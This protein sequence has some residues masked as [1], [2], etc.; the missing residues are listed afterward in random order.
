TAIR[1]YNFMYLHGDPEAERASPLNFEQTDNAYANPFATEFKLEFDDG[2]DN[3]SDDVLCDLIYPNIVTL[4][5]DIKTLKEILQGTEGKQNQATTDLNSY[6]GAIA[7]LIHDLKECVK[8][9]KIKLAATVIKRLDHYGG[10]ITT[11]QL[12]KYNEIVQ[13]WGSFQITKLD[14]SDNLKIKQHFLSV[15]DKEL[16]KNRQASSSPFK[17]KV[18]ADQPNSEYESFLLH[19][20]REVQETGIHPLNNIL[21]HPELRTDFLEAI[22]VRYNLLCKELQESTPFEKGVDIEDEAIKKV[23]L[24]PDCQRKILA[25]LRHYHSALPKQNKQ[26][27]EMAKAVLQLINAMQ[28]NKLKTS[29]CFAIESCPKPKKSLTSSQKLFKAFKRSL[30]IWAVLEQVTAKHNIS[31]ELYL[32]ELIRFAGACGSTYANL[33]LHA[34]MTQQQL[35]AI[36]SL[37]NVPTE[38]EKK[39]REKNL[40]LLVALIKEHKNHAVSEKIVAPVPSYFDIFRQSETKKTYD[41]LCAMV[42][43]S[44]DLSAELTSLLWAADLQYTNYRVSHNKTS[45][46]S[47]FDRLE[48]KITRNRYGQALVRG[49]SAYIQSKASSKK[50]L[51]IPSCYKKCENLSAAGSTANNRETKDLG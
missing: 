40:I 29:T 37:P 28:C 27:I 19:L 1:G 22:I 41:K 47:D 38:E 2:Y 45:N 10:R 36:F 42:A 3:L 18:N 23:F 16:E 4:K 7:Q 8:L 32:E 6:T 30:S 9:A 13:S 35:D 20:K 25:C 39:I 43:I 12:E 50:P 21:R 46:T 34:E 26:Q 33:K 24:N 14:F 51:V 17:K 48:H 49:L 11:E 44:G 5:E 31:L 15:I